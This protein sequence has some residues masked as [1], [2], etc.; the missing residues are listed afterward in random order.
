MPGGVHCCTVVCRQHQPPTAFVP[1]EP[2]GGSSLCNAA[3]CH[4]GPSEFG[5]HLIWL[6][7]P[8]CLPPRLQS[9]SALGLI[10]RSVHAKHVFRGIG[11]AASSGT[12]IDFPL[13][14]GETATLASFSLS[15]VNTPSPSHI[16]VDAETLHPR[17]FLLLRSILF[18]SR[19]ATATLETQS[20]GWRVERG[21]TPV[22]KQ[23]SQIATPPLGRGMHDNQPLQRNVHSSFSGAH[24]PG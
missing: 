15:P 20:H 23:G 24:L 13:R 5:M 21:A 11:L 7:G 16:L 19:E 18:M 14:L 2:T 17:P 8:T 10:G 22:T 4:L 9:K 1:V 12:A 3:A 6:S